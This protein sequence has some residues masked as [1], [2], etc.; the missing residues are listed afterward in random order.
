MDHQVRT[1]GCP[2]QISFVRPNQTLAVSVTGADCA[3][4]CAHCNGHYLRDMVAI[5][6]AD[7]TSKTSC[8]VS[9][10]CDARGR[11]P[12]SASLGRIAALRPGLAL[13]WHVG[14][15]DEE[16]MRT[17]APYVDVIS[18][19]FV[20]DDETIRDVY[21]LPYTVDDYRRTYAMLRRHARVVPHVTIGLHAGQVR[22]EYRALEELKAA[23]LDALVLLVLIPTTG[24]RYAG[25]PP[26]SLEEAA[27]VMHWARKWLPGTPIYLGC[28]RPG[29][30]YRREIDCLAVEAGL[31]KVVNPAPEAVRLARE[32][33]LQVKWENE[34][35]VIQRAQ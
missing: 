3:L 8:L 31:D 2:P 6:D 4:S 5:Q 15:I 7:A 33:G 1:V 13:N 20:G 25:C 11:V 34:C 16:E 24:T 17:I 26:P 22:G 10:G 19:D 9:G 12:F 14:M 29:G 27:S 35:C 21:G 23:G 28:M 30:R 18:F 32:M